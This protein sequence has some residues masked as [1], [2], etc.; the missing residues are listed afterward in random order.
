MGNEKLQSYQQ[1]TWEVT[2]IKF[3]TFYIWIEI[4]KRY[5]AHLIFEMNPVANKAECLFPANYLFYLHVLELCKEAKKYNVIW[6]KRLWLSLAD[7]PYYEC[8]VNTKI[9]IIRKCKNYTKVTRY[10]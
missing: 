8:Y 5:L 6:D 1:E 3:L 4:I 10:A 9:L 7:M 2:A